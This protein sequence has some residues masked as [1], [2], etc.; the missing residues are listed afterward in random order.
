MAVQVNVSGALLVKTG[1][2]S[3][4]AL[5]D[6][7]YSINGVEIQEDVFTGDV[8]GDQNGGDQGPPIDIQYFG[9][10]HRISIDLSKYDPA[11]AAKIQSKY[12]GGTA[13][14]IGTPGSLFIGAT[15]YYRLLL[16]GT[17]FTRNYLG[18]IPRQ[19]MAINA[20]TKFSVQRF[21]FECHAIGGV[22]WNTTTSG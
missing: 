7:G 14:A 1:T 21:V 8:P 20:G 6:L 3:A 17:N 2:G 16:T 12:K 15:T 4:S 11:V 18:A 19:P 10:V 9:E 22:L 5:E 13:G